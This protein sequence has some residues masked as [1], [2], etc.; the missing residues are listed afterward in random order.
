ME[1][2][3][4]GSKSCFVFIE[5]VNL[6]NEFVVPVGH[7]KS[8]NFLK[9]DLNIVLVTNWRTNR[10]IALRQLTAEVFLGS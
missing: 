2:H 1:S 4:V 6:F 3:R 10:E 5:A 8:S 9:H 7:C